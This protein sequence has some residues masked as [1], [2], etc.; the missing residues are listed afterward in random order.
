MKVPSQK[1][2]SLQNNVHT[3]YKHV[4]GYSIVNLAG[5]FL[6]EHCKF[7]RSL[8]RVLPTLLLLHPLKRT[9]YSTFEQTYLVLLHRRLNKAYHPLNKS[10]F[11][12]KVP[13]FHFF[14]DLSQGILHHLFSRIVL[15]FLLEYC[16][17]WC[18]ISTL[19]SEYY[20]KSTASIQ[21][22]LETNTFAK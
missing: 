7:G 3:W 1:G 6:E 2:I 17:K 11:Q 10:I 22:F 12:G 21:D 9:W 15:L 13:L 16:N 4:S 20:F 19:L 18:Y 14:S 5:P 8:W